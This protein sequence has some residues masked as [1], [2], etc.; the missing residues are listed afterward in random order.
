MGVVEARSAKNVKNTH[1]V[2]GTGG[3]HGQG[4]GERPNARQNGDGGGNMDEDSCADKNG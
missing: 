1:T 4:G 3:G 2:G